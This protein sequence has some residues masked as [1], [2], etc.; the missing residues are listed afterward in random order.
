MEGI[1]GLSTSPAVTVKKFDHL[2]MAGK[3]LKGK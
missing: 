3:L 2:K 1:C